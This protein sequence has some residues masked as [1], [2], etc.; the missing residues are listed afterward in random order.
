MAKRRVRKFLA[1]LLFLGVI[2][3]LF[4]WFSPACPVRIK[5]EIVQGNSLTGIVGDQGR[6]EVSY[7]YYR[8]HEINRDDVV[9]YRFSGSAEP[10]LKIVK[11]VPGDAFALVRA[12][13]GFNLLINGAVQT[14]SGAQPYLFDL[15]RAKLLSLYIRDYQGIIP[16][17]AYLILGN[18]REGTLDSSRFGLVSQGDIIGK[19]RILNK[20]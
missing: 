9:V 6:V 18:Q 13:G 10:L 2:L 17:R 15:N 7:G 3:I 16:P 4:Y 19:A 14:N 8:C 11:G 12:P 5:T 1:A 20:Y